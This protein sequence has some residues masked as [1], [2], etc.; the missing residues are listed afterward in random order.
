M[1]NDDD[2]RD[3]TEAQRLDRNYAELLQE[4]RIAQTGIQILF[5]FLLGIAFQQRFTSTDDVQRGIYIAALLSTG[6]ATAFLIAP[7]ALH[8]FLF[9]RQRKD[10]LVAITSRL[11]LCGL[12][13]LLLSVLSGV[14][15]ILDVVLDRTT[16]IVVSALL[17]VV[18]GTLWIA[19][20]LYY[21]RIPASEQ[22][23]SR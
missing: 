14:L 8:R 1:G 17:A 6:L 21:R 4:L 3:E 9:R 12:M 16:A 20:P 2:P 10:H 13:F 11:A 7:V 19:V 23:E 18:F 5:A 15:L 22:Y